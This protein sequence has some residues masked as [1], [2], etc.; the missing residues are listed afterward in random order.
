M[1]RIPRWFGEG[2]ATVRLENEMSQRELAEKLKVSEK[3]IWK[4][5]HDRTRPD[6]DQLGHL[7][8]IFGLTAEQ[9]F[10]RFYRRR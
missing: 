2:L 1:A 5:E 3:T 4:W 9:A 8:V 7:T 6:A 10:R